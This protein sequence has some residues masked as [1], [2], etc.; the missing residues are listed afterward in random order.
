MNKQY[1]S[2]FTPEKEDTI[3]TSARDRGSVMPHIIVNPEGVKKLIASLKPNKA[4]GPDQISPRVLKELAN[5]LYQPL[6]VF[7]Q[8]SLDGGTVPEQ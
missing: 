7:F 8:N 3:P 5:G 6:S 1:S 2:V 4:A